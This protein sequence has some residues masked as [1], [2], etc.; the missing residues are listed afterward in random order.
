MPN[1]PILDIAYEILSESRTKV[2]F[3]ELWTKLCTQVPDLN[4]DD[5]ERTSEFYTQ[6]TFDKRFIN[7]GDNKWDLRERHPYDKVH[8][9]MSDIYTE[10]EEDEEDDFNEED[11]DKALLEKKEI[12]N[13]R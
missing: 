9:S 6:I 5:V 2:P 10:I 1:K 7:I 12:K 11:I 4:K 13:F 8:I 3:L